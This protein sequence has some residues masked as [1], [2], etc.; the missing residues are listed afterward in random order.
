[1]FT[2]FPAIF[3]KRGM[4]GSI[5]SL[6]P[7]TWTS[8]QAS[9][10]DLYGVVYDGSTYWAACGGAYNGG[11][12]WYATNPTGGWTKRTDIPQDRY[13][14]AIIHDGTY[15]INAGAEGRVYTA[16]NP[17][18]TWT[19]NTS[20]S[21]HTNEFCVAYDGS[22]NY[23]ISGDGDT[24]GYQISTA[25]SPTGTWTI[26]EE[27]ISSSAIQGVAYGNSKWVLCGVSGKIATATDP[28]GTWTLH[29][30]SPLSGTIYS[31]FYGNGYWVAVSDSGELYT[32]TDPTS[33]WTEH[34]SSPFANALYGVTYANETWVAVGS[35]GKILTCG[36]DPTGTWTLRLN[37][38]SSSFWDVSYGSDGYWVA[39]GAAGIYTSPASSY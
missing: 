28:T 25:Q 19:K 32:A 12:L 27:P 2:S 20:V 8:R 21:A 11:Y 18:S 30:S 7:S 38:G 35:N 15:F 24:P 16:T 3:N 4:G 31:V 14:R 23:V 22:T 29:A 6:E 34:A 33:T 39:V 10:G 13:Q 17:A 9:P 1:M 26:G 36:K 37:L 5:L